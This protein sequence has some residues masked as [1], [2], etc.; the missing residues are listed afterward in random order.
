[1]TPPRKARPSDYDDLIR[2]LNSIFHKGMDLE[3]S[4]IYKPTSKDMANN[5]VV[6]DGGH[7]VGCV[8]IF[9]MTFVCGD[10]RLSVAGIG[11]VSTEP[12]YRGQGTM[13]E[14]L[15][16]AIS[17]MQRQ[18]YD[19]SI[20]WGDRLRY[21]HFGWENAG[22]QYVF[23]IDRRHV[24]PRKPEGAEIRP[25]SLSTDDLKRIPRLCKQ[26]ELRVHR[27][28]QQLK[29]VLSRYTYETWVWRKGRDFAYMTVKGTTKDRELIESGGDLGGLEDLLSFLVEK[30]ELENLRGTVS[31]GRNPYLSFIL[32][33]SSEWG[34]RFIGMVKI[35]NLRSVLEKF[36]KQIK[37]KWGA[38]GLRHSLT[39]EM[40][41]SDQFATLHLGKRER[42][43]DK[44]KEPVLRLS[45]TEMVRLVFGTV[46]PTH[47]LNLDESFGYLDSIFP[48]DFHVPR[49]DYV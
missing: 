20:L 26:R 44:K 48:L 4:H 33:H 18:N 8:G 27:T 29:S 10:V 3:Y 21:N 16:K 11:G 12:E 39:L 38:S 25:L 23:S 30:Y 24:T 14:L 6:L 31:V 46:P 22:R 19:L 7:I 41:D 28:P 40:T 9:P 37:R 1:M 15:N 32:R 36:S 42:V 34:I 35:L 2:F 43:G 17:V 47:S 13:T 5:I 45:N 49:L